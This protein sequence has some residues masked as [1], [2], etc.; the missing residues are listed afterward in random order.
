MFS[1]RYVNLWAMLPPALSALFAALRFLLWERAAL[2][3]EVH[4]RALRQSP[5]ADPTALRAGG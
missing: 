2:Y 3:A 5:R 4:H 1:V